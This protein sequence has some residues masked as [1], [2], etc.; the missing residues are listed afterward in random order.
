MTITHFTVPCDLVWN[1][2]NTYCS[3][4]GAH[5]SEKHDFVKWFRSGVKIFPVF[6][7]I[8]FQCPKTGHPPTALKIV[9]KRTEKYVYQ[10]YL[11]YCGTL[12]TDGTRIF[13]SIS[14]LQKWS[15][16][17]LNADKSSGI[18]PAADIDLIGVLDV[19]LALVLFEEGAEALLGKAAQSVIVTPQLINGVKVFGT[20]L[21][22]CLE[23]D[24]SLGA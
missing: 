8:D 7:T 20:D 24:I 11:M 3:V 15:L 9:A 6:I 17:K 22:I 1:R 16:Q 2:E 10:V 4:N 5:C 13:G 12:G 19:I 18:P 21:I 23:A 14:F